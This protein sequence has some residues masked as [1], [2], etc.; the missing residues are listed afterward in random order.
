MAALVE[1]IVSR[2][3]R[4]SRRETP[5]PAPLAPSESA[6]GRK[7]PPPTPG[8]ITRGRLPDYRCSGHHGP[9]RRGRTRSSPIHHFR[10]LE[11]RSG[12]LTPLILPRHFSKKL[13]A[14]HAKNENEGKTETQL[15]LS[16]EHFPAPKIEPLSGL[17]QRL[18]ESP[19][20]RRLIFLHDPLETLQVSPD[21]VDGQEIE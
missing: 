2:T 1:E 11:E 12:K 18:F 16:S 9:R 6:T 7:P 10:W 17:G 5:L 13:D 14:T 19:D 20:H 15:P 21:I 3:D 4:R 8:S